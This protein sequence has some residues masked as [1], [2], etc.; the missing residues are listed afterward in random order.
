MLPERK[1][2]SMIQKIEGVT[3]GIG[4]KNVAKATEWYRALLGDIETME[5]APGT[6][7]IKLTDTTWLQLDDTGYLEVGGGS[8]IVRL[9]TKDIEAA[10]AQAK[11]LSADVDDIE[12]VEGVVRYFDFKDLSGNRLSYVQ[13]V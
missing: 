2:L 1:L 9:E 5:P 3:I 11:E 6:I 4:V 12:T 13:L 7:E 8:S 10:H